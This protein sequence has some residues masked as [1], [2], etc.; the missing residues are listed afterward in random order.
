MD[1][2]DIFLVIV[3]VAS[4]IH[5]LK[6]GATVQ[7]FSF[8]AFWIGLGIGALIAPFVVSYLSTPL[9]KAIGS[10][11]IV[12]GSA[13]ILGSF[14][15]RL[16][17]SLWKVVRRIHLGSLDAILGAVVAAAASL[18]TAWLVASML[19]SVPLQTLSYQIQN[20]S[21]L[22]TLDTILPPAPSIFSRIQQLI[23]TPGFPSVFAG[24]QPGF[25][26]PV[27]IAGSY[28]VNSAVSHDA[29]STVK[30]VGIGCGQIQEGSGFIISP[31]LVITN[32]HVVAG[33]TTPVIHAR[34]GNFR[35]S[36]IYF[37]PNYDLAILKTSAT[38][39]GP[40]LKLDPHLVPRG[41]QI[42]VLGYPGGGP[43]TALPGGVMT[44]FR[45]VGRDI[46]GRGLTNRA[47]YEIQANVEPG[48][49][50]G[51]M[52]TSNGTV[53]GIV[54]SKSTAQK[55]V[56]FALTSPGVLKRIKIAESHPSSPGTGACTN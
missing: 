5:G 45:A 8:G 25:Q 13:S 24:I 21:I 46:Y 54:F 39:F 53:L 16:G 38:L 9:E 23:N 30:I 11:I 33:I 17:V 50:G 29:I 49:S 3:V 1:L 26:G 34:N 20:S 43:F 42:A 40:P 36:A 22:Q 10:I 18:V 48:N 12:F 32:A 51:P 56:G 2:I 4:I 6:L 35:S 28:V 15:R 27:K 31:H 7:V 55:N 14:G 52:V 19:V 41:T 44:E 47:V 37:N